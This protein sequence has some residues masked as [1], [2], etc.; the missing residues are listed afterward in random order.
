MSLGAHDLYRL[1]W[2]HLPG[3]PS[4]LGYG[5]AHLVGDAACLAHR[6]RGGQRG[7]GQLRRNLARLL[8]PGTS[9]RALRRATRAAMR[10]Y[11][12]YF[13]E[14]F[15]LSALSPAQLDARV[16]PVVDQDL[17]NDLA[18]GSVVVALPHMGNWDLVGAWVSSHLA[19]VL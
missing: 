10:S 5:L 16:R 4:W 9:E 1:A 17:T 3:A 12:R 11:M 18:R 15:S 8:P 19:Q 6:V 13:Y 14:T 2:R 7:V